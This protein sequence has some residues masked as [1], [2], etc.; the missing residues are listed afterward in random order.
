MVV[1]G[2]HRNIEIGKISDLGRQVTQA[3][4]QLRITLGNTKLFAYW[5]E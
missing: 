5:F 3:A 1:T 4:I 2:D